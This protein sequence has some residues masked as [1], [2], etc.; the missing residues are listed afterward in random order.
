MRPSISHRRLFAGGLSTANK[1]MWRPA[2]V[3]RMERSVIRDQRLYRTAAPIPV[4]YRGTM[5]QTTFSGLSKLLFVDEGISGKELHPA[6][7]TRNPR[8][9]RPLTVDAVKRCLRLQLAIWIKHPDYP[10]GAHSRV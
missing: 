7:Q 3:A 5:R 1:L 8:G 2:A 9:L 4:N 10:D 6:R